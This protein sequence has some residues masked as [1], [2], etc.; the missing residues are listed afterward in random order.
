[1]HLKMLSAL[2]EPM[3][4]SLL[5]HICVTRPQGVKEHISMEF[6][7]K[8]RKVH[9]RKRIYKCCLQNVSPCDDLAMCEHPFVNC[10]ISANVLN[11]IW[12]Y[13]YFWYSAILEIYNHS[14]HLTHF[15]EIDVKIGMWE[16]TS[17]YKH[18]SKL[19]IYFDN[20]W[21]ITINILS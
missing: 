9:S 5:T 8:L 11:R 7:L 19:F 14:S 18:I 16:L 13:M 3:M 17:L 1:M 20:L 21:Y 6:Y 10:E 4:V 15:V 12:I 2:S